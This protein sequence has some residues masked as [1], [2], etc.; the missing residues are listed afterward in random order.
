MK[1]K[2]QGSYG[3]GKP[4]EV[5]ELKKKVIS[6]RGKV[7]GRKKYNP[8]SSVNVHLLNIFTFICIFILLIKLFKAYTRVFTEI[9]RNVW[10]WKFGSK[11]WKPIGVRTLFLAPPTILKGVLIN[12]SPS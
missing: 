5:L 11:S 8:K 12:K 6:R 10:S 3:H 2:F 7:F 9:S 4:G 1:S